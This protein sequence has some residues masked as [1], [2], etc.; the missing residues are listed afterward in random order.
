LLWEHF[1]TPPYIAK[2][3]PVSMRRR[4]LNRKED[5]EKAREA[6]HKAEMAKIKRR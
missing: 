2:N 5:L 3:E 6:R 1:H 4:M